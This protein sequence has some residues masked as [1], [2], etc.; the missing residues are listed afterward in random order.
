MHLGTQVF[1]AQ[2]TA[3]TLYLILHAKMLEKLHSCCEMAFLRAL[4]VC[5]NLQSSPVYLS[6]HSH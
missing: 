3:Y 4:N 6:I 2:V 1:N 5:Q